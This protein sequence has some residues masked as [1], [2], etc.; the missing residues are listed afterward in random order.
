MQQIQTILNHDG[1]NHLAPAAA[2]LP[3][4][5]CQRLK[6][7]LVVLQFTTVPCS[8]YRLSSI[9]MALITSHLRRCSRAA[10]PDG[11]GMVRDIVPVR[12]HGEAAQRTRQEASCSKAAPFLL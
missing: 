7:F 1:P 12:P 11:F 8:K 6:P 5:L 2:S 3:L 4:P 10:P 9:T